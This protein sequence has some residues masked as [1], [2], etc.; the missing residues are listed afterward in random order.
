MFSDRESVIIDVA[1]ASL[2]NV[3]ERNRKS[4]NSVC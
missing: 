2:H 3:I 1:K 4:K